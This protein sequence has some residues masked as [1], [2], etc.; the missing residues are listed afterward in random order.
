M[1]QGLI[2]LLSLC[3]VMAAASFLAGVLPLALNLSSSRLR[4]V[5]TIGM[6][7][8]VGTSLIVIIPEG[9]DT[10]YSTGASHAHTRRDISRRNAAI[11]WSHGTTLPTVAA[12][13]RRSEP[14]LDGLGT[15]GPVIPESNSLPPPKTP[16]EPGVVGILEESGDADKHNGGDEDMHEEAHH[17][18]I[19]VALIA[20]FILMF[21]IDKLPQYTATDKPRTHTRHISLTNLG[22]RFNLTTLDRQ[23]EADTFLDTAQPVAEPSRR[24]FATTTGLVIHAA[25]DGIALGASSSTTNTSLS[26]VIF[27]AIMVHKAPAA[28]GLTSVLLKQ[29]LSK[30]MARAHLIVFSLAAPA[31][32]FLTFLLANVL[33]SGSATRSAENSQWW[34]GILLLFSAGTFLYVAM[35]SMQEVTSPKNSETQM[36]GAANGSI[37]EGREVGPQEEKPSISDLGAAIFGMILP[38]FLQVGHAH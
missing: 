9:V 31:G 3:V 22:R 35:H 33:G 7:V 1:A 29:G 20:G 38:L 11:A 10:L 14:A 13:E 34:T 16:T 17:A 15:P 12:F 2:T 4:L 24:S 26:F 25:A 28:F 8:L 36:N 32:A 23:E 27:F 30:R 19:G 37:H 18:W 6:G 21:L 5:S